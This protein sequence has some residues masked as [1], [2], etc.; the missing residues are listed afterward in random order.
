MGTQK[1]FTL[2][3]L[4]ITMAIISV[5]AAMAAPAFQRYAINGYLKTAARDIASHIALLKGRAAAENRIYRMELNVENGQYT[6][7]QCNS[8]G[9][10][11]E[12]WS[13]IEVKDLRNYSGDI[14]FDAEGTIVTDYRFRPRGTVT[15]GAMV[16]RN[17]RGSIASVTINMTG[18]AN[19][20]FAFQ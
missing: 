11:C 6:L 3:E 1:G 13:D 20:Q 9:V 8:L 18:R 2:I 19:V 5:V 10:P 14:A 12:G 15:S 16:L 7:K 4:V 17:S